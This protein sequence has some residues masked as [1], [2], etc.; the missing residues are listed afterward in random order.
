MQELS[1]LPRESFTQK[2]LRQ[3]VV[4][5]LSDEPGESYCYPG[6]LMGKRASGSLAPSRTRQPRRYLQHRLAA[7]ERKNIMQYS[8]ETK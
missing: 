8:L 1:A 7:M 4:D 5:L 2:K 3:V 6:L